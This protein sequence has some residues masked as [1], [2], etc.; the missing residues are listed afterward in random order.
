[1]IPF[2]GRR[3]LGDG[4]LPAGANGAGGGQ[5]A[6]VGA[7]LDD[8]AA[9]RQ[10]VDDRRAQLW[11]GERFV[12]AEKDSLEAIATLAFFSLSVKYLE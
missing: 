11:V 7:G 9:E 12:H 10:S 1:V 2:A 5:A 8:V 6:G 4:L 3:T